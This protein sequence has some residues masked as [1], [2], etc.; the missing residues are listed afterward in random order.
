MRVAEDY[1]W[2]IMHSVVGSLNAQHAVYILDVQTKS[3]LGSALCL[4]P[5]VIRTR[6]YRPAPSI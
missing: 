5:N 4:E 3:P 1:V 6:L 2:P